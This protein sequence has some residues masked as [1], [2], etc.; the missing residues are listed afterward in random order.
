LG[1]TLRLILLAIL[2]AAPAVAIQI[3]NEYDLRRARVAEVKDQVLR[4]ARSETAEIDRIVEGARQ[5]LVALAQISPVKD[6]DGP[7]CNDLLTRIAKNYSAYRA[8]IAADRDGSVFCSSIGPGP[9]ISD[10][11]YF[12]IAMQSGDFAVGDYVVM[13]RGTGSAGLHFA[14]PL[15]DETGKV[16][17]VIAAALDLDWFAER[18]KEKLPANAALNVADRNG[19]ILVRVPGNDVWRGRSVPQQFRGIIYAKAPGV[20]EVMG[21]DGVKQILGYIPIPASE[22]GLHVGVAREWDAVF[23][24]L[25]RAGQRALVL[26]GLGLVLSFLVVWFWGEYGIKGPIE[27][28]LAAVESWRS[29]YYASSG[30]AWGRSELGQL[31]QAFDDLAQT[32]ADRERKLVQSESRLKERERYLSVVLDRVPASIMQTAPD[33]RYLFVNRGFCELT[34]RTR[35]ELIGLSFEAITHPDDIAANLDLF[36][37]ANTTGQPYSLRKR[38]IRPDGT[39]VWT[40]VTVTRLED[41]EDSVLA[42]T[43]DLTERRRA[44]EQQRLLVNELN[45][46]VKNT[47]ASVQALAH[48]TKRHAASIDAYYAA[49]SDRLKALSDTHN[50]LTS[51][52]WEHVGL[53][54]LV[55]SELTPYAGDISS[56]VAVNGE[57]I[58]LKPAD[59]LALGMVFHE[60]ATNAAKYGALSVPTGRVEVRWETKAENESRILDLHWGEH[61]GPAVQE[62]TNKGFGSRLIEESIKSLHGTAESCFHPAGL[63]C[64]IRFP[65]S[66]A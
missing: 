45:H 16:S 9:S 52:L 50:L 66:Q 27:N 46:R 25:N 41:P 22:S 56:R 62:P 8:L 53:F 6:K 7:A 64:R 20:T 38:Y 29:G 58:R 24:D 28:L 23:A 26:I 31:G 21:L 11:T 17:G 42:I 49:F 57:P 44:E 18:L 51:G 15:Q 48:M 34:G 2:A 47:L 12:K 33:G 30:T 10:R 1:L 55:S 36:K 32:V 40:E 14:F 54:D 65:L 3:W 37:R 43:V 4:L 61:G 60:L 19:T 39:V 63:K 13:G 5:F 35:E 59:A